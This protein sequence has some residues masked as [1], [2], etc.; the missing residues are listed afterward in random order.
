M[1]QPPDDVQRPED[2]PLPDP[3]APPTPP[4]P[5]ETVRGTGNPYA[6]PPNPSAAPTP[7]PPGAAPPYPYGSPPPPVRPPPTSYGPSVPPNPY[8]VQPSPPGAHP[9]GNPYRT[10]PAPGLPP[11]GSPYDGFQQVPERQT[12]VS[13][14]VLLILSGLMICCVVQIPATILAIVALTKQNDDPAGSRRLTRYGWIAF[15]VGVALAVAVVS[16]I[17]ASGVSFDDSP[18]NGYSY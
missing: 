2:E 17:A 4:T 1:S 16:I 13:A 15:G 5:P 12:N 3:T 8:A 11:M 7:P 18:S 10:D 6:A 14:I 9:S